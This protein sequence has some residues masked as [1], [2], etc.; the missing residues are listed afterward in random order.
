MPM[1]P[2]GLNG[3]TIV[4]ALAGFL[5]GSMLTRG[6]EDQMISGVL[7]ATAAVGFSG[8]IV[9]LPGIKDVV[10]KVDELLAGANF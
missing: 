8:A 10:A 6:R 3:R 5:V 7:G 1:P 4:P 9:E 2:I